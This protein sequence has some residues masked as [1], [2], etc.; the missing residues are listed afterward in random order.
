VRL[1]A[2][3]GEE[4]AW[5]VHGGG[6]DVQPM[7]RPMSQEDSALLQRV[8]ANVRLLRK[9]AGLTVKAAARCCK[10]DRR[11]WQKVES[12]KFNVTIQTAV[13]VALT[14]KVDVEA[15]FRRPAQFESGAGLS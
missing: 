14:L 3:G 13:R 12:G 9:T 8:A 1:R 10:I 11:Q 2:H 6:V 15:L 7:M 4:N 5:P